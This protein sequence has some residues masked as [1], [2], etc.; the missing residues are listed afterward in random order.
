[1]L[2]LV[3]LPL[4]AGCTGP[5]AEQEICS[6]RLLSWSATTETHSSTEAPAEFGLVDASGNLTWIRA[7]TRQADNHEV[8]TSGARLLNMTSHDAEVALSQIMARH[9]SS[10]TLTIRVIEA[11][12]RAIDS[13]ESPRICGLL[14]EFVSHPFP[15]PDASCEALVVWEWAVESRRG[16][17]VRHIPCP[18]EDV[19]FMEFYREF[20]PILRQTIPP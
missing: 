3:A 12:A 8:V 18:D 15:A 19:P 9:D 6:E 4:F 20:Y 17:V 1:M 11:G 7:A 16:E 13:R 2:L 5:A 10:N 14:A